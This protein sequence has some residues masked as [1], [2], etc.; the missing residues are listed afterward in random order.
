MS[1]TDVATAEA[2]ARADRYRESLETMRD[3]T[4]T[5]AKALAA[6]GTAGLTAVGIQKVADLFPYPDGG[7]LAFAIA[8]LAFLT[9]VGVIT[10]FTVRLYRASEALRTSSDP[11]TMT[12]DAG[13]Q[14]TITTVY[15]R[16]AAAN[17][18]ESLS[19]YEQ[20]AHT[21]QGQADADGN[22]ADRKR[23]LEKA[24]R[25][26]AEVRATQAN[27]AHQVIS[28]RLTRALS[29]GLTRRLGLAFVVALLA[30][31]L[32]TDWLDSERSARTT[33]LKG[34]ADA[35]TAKVPASAL[36][37]FCDAVVTKAPADPTA[38]QEAATRL[39]NLAA[40]YAT[41]VDT[42]TEDEQPLTTCDSIRTRL[43]TAAR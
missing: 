21:L 14:E 19:A 37:D 41:C 43:Q 9:M 2:A 42:A 20:Q 29:D 30:F 34:C 5:A 6:L 40:L 38:D 17:G 28:G 23:L 36:P 4:D 25:I 35:V 8:L 16:V 11:N 26:R 31:G 33:A 18:V 3:R 10:V 24:A 22:D 7:W 15:D 13:E 27:A 39:S 32:S 12:D 1:E